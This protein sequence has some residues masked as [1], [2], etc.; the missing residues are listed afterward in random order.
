MN[1]PVP[2]DRII[3]SCFNAG[4]IQPRTMHPN[5]QGI[6]LHNPI[7]AA[8]NATGVNDA[9]AVFTYNLLSRNAFNNP[10]YTEFLQYVVD[11]ASAITATGQN[12]SIE[13]VAAECTYRYMGDLLIQYPQIQQYVH[14]ETVRFYMDR[15]SQ[16]AMTHDRLQQVPVQQAPQTIYNP[17]HTGRPNMNQGTP[18]Y[19]TQAQQ[20]QQMYAPAQPIDVTGGWQANQA[21]AAVSGP[22]RS[23]SRKRISLVPNTAPIST[24]EQPINNPKE[25]NMLVKKRK[26]VNVSGVAPVATPVPQNED[27]Y[28]REQGTP[29]SEKVSAPVTTE[30]VAGSDEY[31]VFPRQEQYMDD[32]YG[33]IAPSGTVIACGMYLYPYGELTA[34]HPRRRFT[35]VPGYLGFVSYDAPSE[36]LIAVYIKETVLDYLEHELVP[37]RTMLKPEDLMDM[38]DAKKNE[39]KVIEINTLDAAWNGDGVRRGSAQSVA[40]D[41]LFQCAKVND[42]EWKRTAITVACTDVEWLAMESDTN[43]TTVDGKK[44]QS[45]VTY[46]D[47][48]VRSLIDNYLCTRDVVA[49]WDNIVDDLIDIKQILKDEHAGDDI[50]IEDI[51]FN[52]SSQ[53]NKLET[54]DSMFTENSNF[55]FG[56][57][58]VKFDLSAFKVLARPYT[59][60]YARIN[61][62]PEEAGI[63]EEDVTGANARPLSAKTHR[64]IHQVATAIF[65][66]GWA[67]C[68]DRPNVLHVSLDDGTEL[69]VYRALENR[70]L[71]YRLL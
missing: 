8:I 64:H 43:T 45:Y 10:S 4:H 23:N 42:D 48:A 56:D 9:L 44:E 14:P 70:N 19:P 3:P 34:L 41:L 21:T 33:G 63:G 59:D 1:L 49:S 27:W 12:L 55:C 47:T 71:T 30:P 26:R 52:I 53:A 13:P 28:N 39:V 2:M 32:T 17:Q 29:V 24:P 18:L 40:A 54:V 65:G 68:D 15:S 57:S 67:F 46:M 38:R 5:L 69:T 50:S 16:I 7:I 37:Q 35:P 66:T 58:D 6:D 20:P 22:R 61:V 11:I 36:K 51:V 25:T 31:Y 62:S 60:L